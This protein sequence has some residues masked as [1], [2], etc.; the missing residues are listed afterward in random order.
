[1]YFSLCVTSCLVCFSAAAACAFAFTFCIF[2]AF[3]LPPS[4]FALLQL[5]SF[6]FELA[7]RSFAYVSDTDWYV[8]FN[9]TITLSASAFSS[10]PFNLLRFQFD[11]SVFI[12]MNIG[13]SP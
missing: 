6:S 9:V 12:N 8:T 7:S 4:H 11:I 1:M 3:L 10:R 5:F 2:F 13:M